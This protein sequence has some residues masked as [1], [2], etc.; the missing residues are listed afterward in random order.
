VGWVNA[1]RDA[2]R[3]E[4]VISPLTVDLSGHDVV[5]L[6]SPIWLYSP[7][8]PIWEFVKRNRFDGKRVVLFNTFNS[9]FGRN[10]PTKAI[11]DALTPA[12][13]AAC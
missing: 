11:V 2:K 6:G 13:L 8:P 1:M 10:R 3:H 9:R 4:A 7:A 5:Y 12:R